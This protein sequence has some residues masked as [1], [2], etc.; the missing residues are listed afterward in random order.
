WWNE[1][2]A[3]D[4]AFVTNLKHCVRAATLSMDRIL[5]VR[6]DAVFIFSEST[7]YVHPG[8]PSVV[9]RAALLNERRFL[10]L[11]LLLAHDVSATM[12]RYLT[13]NGMTE[14]EYVEFMT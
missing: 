7:E 4:T 9:E 8:S 11:D 6:P 1:G 12:Y 5:A 2:L 3:S 10:S 13:S 14:D